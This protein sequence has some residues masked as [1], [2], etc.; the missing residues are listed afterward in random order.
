M[1]KTIDQTA[2]VASANEMAAHQGEIMQRF[3]D[4]LPYDRIR[5]VGEA[6][7]YMAQSAE[8]MLEAG[9]RLIVLK[10]SEPHGEFVEI[11][12]K[13]LGLAARTA[14]QMMQATLKYFSPKLQSKAQALAH[15]GK[16]KLFEL[17]AADDEEL[18]ELTEGGTVAGL[19]L[20]D[21]DRMT[22]RELRRA[23][24]EARENAA[25]V[26]KVTAGKDDK[27]NKLDAELTRLKSKATEPLIEALEPD[28]KAE[29]LLHET[30]V[31]ADEI[32][33]RIDGKLLPAFRALSNH[34]MS[35]GSQH[36]VEMAAMLASIEFKLN[37]LRGDFDL[38]RQLDG[39][40]TPDWLRED[41]DEVVAA[42]LEQAQGG[43]H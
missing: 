29:Q 38:P 5:V 3:G 7:F 27:I 20:D 30:R 19:T 35:T 22:T 31:W 1:S 10:E 15:L 32:K 39:D 25:A 11:V 21:V 17:M 26:A 18:V 6:R 40:S 43:A 36:Q 37:C 13:D 34:D 16:T 12:E 42:A 23:L 24:R 41:A 33:A 28:A 4:G 2:L 8:A 9:K 14:Q